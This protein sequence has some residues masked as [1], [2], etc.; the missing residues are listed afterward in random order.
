LVEVAGTAPAS[1]KSRFN[2][3]RAQ[4][5]RSCRDLRGVGASRDP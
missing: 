4:P 3:L 5:T 1:V 2:L